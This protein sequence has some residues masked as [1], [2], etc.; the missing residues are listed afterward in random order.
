MSVKQRIMRYL[1]CFVIAITP[2]FLIGCGSSDDGGGKS[3]AGTYQAKLVF[4]ADTPRLESGGIDCETA[5]IGAID[6]SFTRNDALLKSVRFACHDGRAQ[7]SDIPA[8]VD[9]LVEAFVYDLQETLMLRGSILAVIE[10]GKVT[11]GQEIML[12]YIPITETDSDTGTDGDTDTDT[13]MNTEPNQPPNSFANSLGMTFNLIPT[14]TFIVGSPQSELGRD[15][16]ETQHQV[17]LTQPFYLQITEVTQDQWIEIMGVNPSFF[18]SCGPFCPVENVSWDDVQIFI[19]ELNRRD[20]GVYR[21]P[22][23]AEW[24][25]AARGGRTTAFSSGDIETIECGM[26]T[27]LDVMGWYCDNSIVEYS[28]CVNLVEGGGPECVGPH[29]VQQ[30]IPNDY[31]LYDMHG[32]IAEWCNDW[33]ISEISVAPVTNPTGPVSGERRVLRG[34]CWFDNP[35]ICR[36][37][38]R[39][40]AEPNFRD[41]RIGFRLACSLPDSQ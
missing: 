33:Y 38:S 15:G 30:K 8:G 39:T 1:I 21:L 6:I 35:D 4:P 28:G 20:E 29:P 9:V 34:G 3:N 16:D 11:E 19:E 26:D 32:N 13:G 7:I 31:G 41:R 17:T 14:G 37:A 5:G 25:Y 40:R 24:E 18:S 2:G 36:S 23:E 10:A 27:N 12:N 22:T